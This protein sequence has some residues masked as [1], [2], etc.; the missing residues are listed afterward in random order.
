MFCKLLKT[1]NQ[2]SPG[3][4]PVAILDGEFIIIIV[5]MILFIY[6]LN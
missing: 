4:I 6:F 1:W 2:S 3:G 5:I